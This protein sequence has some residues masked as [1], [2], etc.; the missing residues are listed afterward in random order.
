MP[1]SPSVDHFKTQPYIAWQRYYVKL[2]CHLTQMLMKTREN[3]NILHKIGFSFTTQL[4][5]T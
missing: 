4:R 5:L 2:S 1:A 3:Y